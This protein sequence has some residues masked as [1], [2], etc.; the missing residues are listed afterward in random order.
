MATS[1]E[2][3]QISALYGKFCFPL[4]VHCLMSANAIVAVTK[5][6]RIDLSEK[7]TSRNVF[8]CRL[9]GPKDAGKSSFMKKFIGKTTQSSGPKSDSIYNSYVI[10]SI[11]IYGHRKY[12]IVSGTLVVVG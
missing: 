8:F 2:K 5:D 10:N 4:Y 12:L 7:Q 9:I 6:K 11:M 3:N 1:G